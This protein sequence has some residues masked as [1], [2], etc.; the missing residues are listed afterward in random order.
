MTS[1]DSIINRQ[2][3]RWELE[4]DRSDQQVP[5]LRTPTPVVTV[6]RLTGSRGS[7]F[8]SRLALKLGYQR[9][10]RE[11]IDVICQSSGYYKRIIESL[12]MH[13]RSRLDILVESLL[14]G[15]SVDND[16]YVRYL[17][18]V[19]LSM[20]QLGGVVLMGRGGNFILGPD[21]GF[22]IQIVCPKPQ[23]IENLMKY[24]GMADHEAAHWIE[25]TDRER[26]EFI[27]HVFHANIE[28]ANHYDL[29]L[30]SALIDV[31]DMVDIAVLAMNAKWTKL[32]HGHDEI[33]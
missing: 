2:I 17:Y 19:V 1:I 3:L 21:R 27:S 9:L 7:Y 22:H 28:D 24:K 10:H 23:R 5:G 6:S 14:T 13:F 25:K 20:S 16:D 15:Q 26:K 31:E 29:V 4:K 8:G 11:I 12:D 18:K 33:D 30:N 32:R